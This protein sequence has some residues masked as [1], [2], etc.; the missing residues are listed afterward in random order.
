MSIL[1]RP[2][3]A[4]SQYHAKMDREANIQPGED[5]LHNPTPLAKSLGVA[6]GLSAGSGS[7]SGSG[8]R[9]RS[10]GSATVT[11][12][13]SVI[14]PKIGFS[15]SIGHG[16]GSGIVDGDL[17]VTMLKKEAEGVIGFR[18]ALMELE[19]DDGSEKESV[20]DAGARA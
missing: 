15:P 20:G 7:G 9:C 14:T 5:E 13:G 19:E 18:A 10:C 11:A 17:G 16:H 2:K 4:I 12:V 6:T 1:L 8:S 3:W